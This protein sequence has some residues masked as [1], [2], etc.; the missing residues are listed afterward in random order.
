MAPN[1]RARS[2]TSHSSSTSR[3]IRAASIGP[4]PRT[5]ARRLCRFSADSSQ[6]GRRR[7]HRDTPTKHA[8]RS[9]NGRGRRSSSHR[10]TQVRPV[11]ARTIVFGERWGLSPPGTRRDCNFRWCKPHLAQGIDVLTPCARHYRRSRRQPQVVSTRPWADRRQ[12]RQKTLR[13]R[14]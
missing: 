2:A 9:E 14:Q 5:P 12:A 4:T 7:R 1:R 11:M 3:T 6:D 13:S 8:R 10:P